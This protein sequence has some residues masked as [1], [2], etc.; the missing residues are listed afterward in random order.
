MKFSDLI[1]ISGFLDHKRSRYNKPRTCGL[2]EYL[3]YFWWKDHTRPKD[4]I[5][6]LTTPIVTTDLIIYNLLSMHIYRVGIHVFI[7][8]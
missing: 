3:S 2:A 4:E 1:H 6:S 8:Y 5:K 7:P